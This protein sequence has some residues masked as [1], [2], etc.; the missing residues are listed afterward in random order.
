MTDEPTALLCMRL[1]D[2][3]LI[4]PQQDDSRVCGRCGERVGIYPSGQWVLQCRPDVEIVCQV[5]AEQDPAQVQVP[6]P[7]ALEEVG[8]GIPKRRDPT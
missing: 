1:A 4:H 3:N 2:M 5:C 7:G 8:E 6:A